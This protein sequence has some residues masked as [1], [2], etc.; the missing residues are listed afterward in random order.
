MAGVPDDEVPRPESSAGQVEGGRELI[1]GIERDIT[2][3][4]LLLTL[5]AERDRRAVEQAPAVDGDRDASVIAARCGRDAG[6]EVPQ[7]LG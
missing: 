1:A 7:T 5:H 2:A 4:D 6:D 3:R